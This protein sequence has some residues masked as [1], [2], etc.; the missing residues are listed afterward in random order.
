MD[1]GGYS[2]HSFKSMCLCPV[3]KFW[4]TAIFMN[5]LITLFPRF[6]LTKSSCLLKGTFNLKEEFANT[7]LLQNPPNA[8][9]FFFQETTSGNALVLWQ[10][11]FTKGKES[12]IFFLSSRLSMSLKAAWLGQWRKSRTTMTAQSAKV[13]EDPVKHSP[14]RCFSSFSRGSNHFGK[15]SLRYS[16]TCKNN[17][18]Y[19]QRCQVLRMMEITIRNRKSSLCAQ[20]IKRWSLGSF[21]QFHILF[22]HGCS[23]FQ[24]VFFTRLCGSPRKHHLGQLGPNVLVVARHLCGGYIIPKN[25]G[26]SSKTE[27]EGKGV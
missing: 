10:L 22:Y 4:I 19:L 5:V 27:S 9:F 8:G 23:L 12:K 15:N 16:F 24:R 6:H 18:I 2:I 1:T 21:S 26:F 14:P 17:T 11:A 20:H 25:T 13:A 3:R 7:S